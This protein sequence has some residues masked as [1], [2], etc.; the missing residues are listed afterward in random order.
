L[1]GISFKD[2]EVLEDGEEQTLTIEGVLPEN[3]TVEYLNNALTEEGQTEAVAIFKKNGEEIERR[4]WC[5][6][7]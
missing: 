6:N 4:F 2:K 7:N 5:F 3:V 1:S